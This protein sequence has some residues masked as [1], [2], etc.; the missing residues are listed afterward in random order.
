MA[1]ARATS[2]EDIARRA[3]ELADSAGLEA[4]TMRRLAE[5]VGLPTMTLYGYFATKDELLDAMADAAVATAGIAP[6]G[7]TWREQLTS[8]MDGVRQVLHDHPSGVRIRSRGPVL[9]PAALRISETAVAILVDAGSRTATRRSPTAASSSSR[10]ATP[11]STSAATT[12]RRQRLRGALAALPPDEHPMLSTDIDDFADAS[13]RR[14]GVP[15]RARPPAR[16][17]RAA[18]QR[19]GPGG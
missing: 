11:P 4:V 5:H 7:A 3:L 2:R 17:A 8:L 16:R 12:P 10:S 13:D 15:L 14:R 9:G 1:V 19:V 18:A 6:T